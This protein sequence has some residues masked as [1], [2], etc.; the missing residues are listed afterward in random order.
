MEGCGVAAPAR[1]PAPVPVEPGLIREERRHHVEHADLD[2][3]AAAGALA[4]EQRQR[5]AVGGRHAGDEIGDG[6]A[7][8]DGRPVGKAR[9]VHHAGL[10]LHD[11]VV[12]RPRGLGAALAEPGDRAV[13]QPRV[14]FAKGLEAEAEALH[15]AGTEV[16]QHYIGARDEPAQDGLPL[17]R[18][19][20]EGE[21][22]LAAINRHEVGGLA[23]REG[24]PSARVVSLA[25]LL[26][27]DD[28]GA[29]VAQRHGAEGARQH[30]GE[31]DD[32]DA[33]QRR[34]C[35]GGPAGRRL[36]GSDAGS[37]L[38]HSISL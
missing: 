18:L 32:A 31:V 11:E 15:R 23:P 13:D 3:L 21:A 25:R 26:D 24:R 22:L 17:R 37:S 27:L 12:A 34:P 33:R 20:V 30:A 29:H 6:V 38:G 16:L 5:D 2:L 9:E 10:A 35:R 28:L 7:H 14:R 8:L 19:E 36:P 1:L 4:R